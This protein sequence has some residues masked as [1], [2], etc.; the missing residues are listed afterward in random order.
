MGTELLFITLKWRYLALGSLNG[1]EQYEVPHFS[2]RLA[3]TDS[4]V[5]VDLIRYVPY[6]ISWDKVTLTLESTIF[7]TYT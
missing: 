4:T 2:S 7:K 3:F 6:M 5:N 1:G